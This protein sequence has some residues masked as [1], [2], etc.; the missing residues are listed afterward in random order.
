MQASIKQRHIGKIPIYRAEEVH[1]IDGGVNS[2]AVL[3]GDISWPCAGCA[4]APIRDK[5][6][7]CI[8]CNASEASVIFCCVD[9]MPKCNG[10]CHILHNDVLDHM[11]RSGVNRDTRVAL[12]AVDARRNI[13][14]RYISIVPR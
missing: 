13:S 10:I 4:A 9:C 11:I 3:K 2:H 12:G 14:A 7:S 6:V 5:A 8:E 1:S